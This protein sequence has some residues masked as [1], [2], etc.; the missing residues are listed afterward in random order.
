MNATVAGII[1]LRGAR[2]QDGTFTAVNLG[3]AT[4]PPK[5]EDRPV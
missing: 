5:Q 2:I 4:T 1:D 3:G